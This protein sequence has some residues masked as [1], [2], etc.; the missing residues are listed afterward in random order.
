M[1]VINYLKQLLTDVCRKN[2][3]R[4][5]IIIMCGIVGYTG[6]ENAVPK[7]IKGLKVLEYRGYD[8]V[9]I[10]GQLNGG[11]ALSKCKGRVD[12]LRERL[13]KENFPE[14]TC[15]IGHTRW[16]THGGPS[17]IN[18]HP[19]AT[20]QLALVHNGIIENYRELKAELEEK[21]VK[22]ISETDT[23]VAARVI[24]DEYE[25]CGNAQKAIFNAT[26]RIVGSYAFGIVFKDLPG[27]L[28]AM[29]K[30]SP[31]IVATG[32]D[33][34]YI[35]SDMTALLP[36]TNVF[37]LLEEGVLAHLTKDSVEL[38]LSNGEIK[39]PE[40]HKS[41]LT[42][43]AAE[44]CGYDHFM[45]KE[46]HEQPDAFFKTVSARIK[47]GLPDFSGDGISDDLFNKVNRIYVVACGSAMHAGLVGKNLIEHWARIPVTVEIASEFRYN[48][49]IID[50]KTL[51]IIVS[52]SG[53]TADSLAA[54]RY[55]KKHGAFTFGIINVVGSS[56][57]R[58][59]DATLYTYAG[60]EIAVATTK[61]YC[62]QVAAFMLIAAKL[63]LISK[64][65]SENEVKELCAEILRD[66][67]EAINSTFAL[68][69]RIKEIAKEIY[70]TENL[71]YIG[72]GI[73][74][75][76][77]VEGSLKLKEISY[78]HSEAYAAG[79]LKHGTISLITEGTPVIAV[80]TSDAL[81][82]KTVSNIRECSSRGANVLFIC[83]N[84]AKQPESVANTVLRLPNVGKHAEMLA[85][86]TAMQLIAYE[87][88]LLRGC[89]IDK[90]RNLAKSVTVE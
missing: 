34:S 66:V 8:S 60:P 10:A 42:V 2:V 13:E 6:A 76:L 9:G 58:E 73:D 24:T 87:V 79:E 77:G 62:V 48:D 41:D 55:G 80:S 38:V 25:K 43:E 46:I 65:L 40:W 17:D 22:F 63:A 11:I 16:A 78:I 83:H 30:D 71:F 15:G 88:A 31:L 12:G 84:G 74:Y 82:D 20:E 14:L 4:R 85:A 52:Q 57:A 54:L 75:A 7:I 50:D 36:F 28:F 5:E 45:L 18:A 39:D 89:D 29:R 59:A 1:C 81:Y 72:R 19:H 90:P 67:P 37:H 53:E 61:G 21:G 47:N 68:H 23:E 26:K 44:K 56:I 86:M 32:V 69:D 33:G 49:P 3:F 70:D 35:A 27:E 64:K 51:M